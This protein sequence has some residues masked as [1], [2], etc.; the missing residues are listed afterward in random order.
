LN[1]SFLWNA[2]LIGKSGYKK[3]KYCFFL[4][5]CGFQ[6]CFNIFDDSYLKFLKKRNGF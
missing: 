1:A 2:I 5:G 3:T 6:T 4:G